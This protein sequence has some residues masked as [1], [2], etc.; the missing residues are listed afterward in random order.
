MAECWRDV[1]LPIDRAADVFVFLLVC[2]LSIFYFG[3]LIES[4]DAIVFLDESGNTGSN[5][6]D[7]AQP[8]FVQAAFVYTEKKQSVVD[9]ILGQACEAMGLRELKF[10]GLT[11][12]KNFS[13]FENLMS[14]LKRNCVHV[15]F[16]VVDKQYFGSMM[17]VEYL[18]DS[19]HNENVPNIF[20]QTPSSKQHAA[21][22]FCREVPIEIRQLFLVALQSGDKD[23]LLTAKATF[24]K[25]ATDKKLTRPI[26]RWAKLFDEE[27]YLECCAVD[28]KD[29]TPHFAEHCSPNFHAFSMIHQCLT[30]LF[31]KEKFMAGKLCSDEQRQY[32]KA[33]AWIVEMHQGDKKQILSLPGGG[34]FATGPFFDGKIKFFDSR[35]SLGIQAADLAASSCAWLLRKNAGGDLPDYAKDAYRKQI[36]H[37]VQSMKKGFSYYAFPD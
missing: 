15:C 30:R 36:R 28:Q 23:K 25:H 35:E 24:E 34:T 21:A 31:L 1:A 9:S 6:S 32:E 19:W 37:L 10:S 22:I 33:F 12:H 3:E 13:N 4:S 2:C 7:A 20:F 17:L 16:S 27:K 26:Y 18:L 14:E 8:Y 11:K 5:I 29:R